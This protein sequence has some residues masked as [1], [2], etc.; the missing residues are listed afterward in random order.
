MIW[1]AFT[2]GLI[3]SMHC[4]GMCGAIALA[5]PHQK[6]N[7]WQTLGNV[8]LYNM[9][10]ILT[11][12]VLGGVIGLISQ[13]LFLAHIQKWVSVALGISLIIV[14]VFS[15]NVEHKLLKA[16]WI[17][18]FYFNVKIQLSKYLGG[19]GSVSF[20]KIG[21][22]NGFLPCGLVYMAIVG[23]LT[24]E[25]FVGSIS[26]MMLFGLGTMP[27]MMVTA[28]AGQMVT[29]R[30]RN[31]LKKVYPVFLLGFAA[32]LIM[33]GLNLELPATMDILMF[34]RHEVTCH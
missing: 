13:G 32:L 14:A 25:G 4:V 23:A 30:F 19:S 24:V 6:V 2:I 5:L 17:S 7:K 3:G 15:I 27:L 11:Y 18:R 31:I 8:F 12:M 28:L 20:L 21:L 16:D 22:L 9:G 10:R 33:R 29:V 1:T 26:Y 34:K